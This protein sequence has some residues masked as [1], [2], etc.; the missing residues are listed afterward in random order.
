MSDEFPTH[1]PAQRSRGRSAVTTAGGSDRYRDG[2]GWQD[3]AGYSRGVRRGDVIAVSGTTADSVDGH[4]VS[5]HDT[6][7]QVH[8]AL[9]AVIAAVTALGGGIDDIVR[10]RLLLTPDADWEAACAVHGEIFAQVLPAN[11]TYRVAGLLGEGFLVEV[12][13]DAILLPGGTDG[14]VPVRPHHGRRGNHGRQGNHARRSESGGLRGDGRQRI[15]GR[16]G[17]ELSWCDSR[18]G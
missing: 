1:P 6:K 14:L 5:P 12:E 11:S 8:Q 17:G 10:T 3:S 7:A 4:V 2:S 15:P 9:A 13:A 16:A 18:C